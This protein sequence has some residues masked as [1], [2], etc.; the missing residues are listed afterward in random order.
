MLSVGSRPN[1]MLIILSV[2][3]GTLI[4]FCGQLSL[5]LVMF[6]WLVKSLLLV[7]VCCSVL[8]RLFVLRCVAGFFLM[9]VI[10]GLKLDVRDLGGHLD[11]TLRWWS[12]TLS[13]RVRLVI[14]RLDLNFCLSS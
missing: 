10:S 6:G 4:C 9:R 12:S 5:L 8:L 14:S 11:T 3:L 1:L 13:L 7:S 2:F